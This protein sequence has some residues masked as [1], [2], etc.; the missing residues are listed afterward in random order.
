MLP[1]RSSI[2]D[3]P[4]KISTTIWNTHISSIALPRTSL[5]LKVALLLRDR[6]V[7]SEPD[8][9]SISGLPTGTARLFGRDTEL[10][11]LH[12]AWDSPGAG[13]I[14]PESPAKTNIVMMHAIGGAG[15]SA[16]IRRFLND[17]ADNGYPGAIRVYGWSAYSQGAGDNARADAD[18]FISQVLAFFGHDLSQQPISDPVERGRM[19][20]RL[21]RKHRTLLVLDGLE[22]L[23][24]FPHINEERLKD[25]WPAGH[26]HRV[27]RRQSRPRRH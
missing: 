12:K 13:K 25:P 27:G 24:D 3:C 22:P 1:N 23:Q 16:L 2:P 10:S 15:K 17:L 19:L 21:I 7:P 8:R 9:V 14:V 18:S 5:S 6:F 20:A 26:D 11:I 4:L